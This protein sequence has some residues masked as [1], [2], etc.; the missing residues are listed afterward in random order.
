MATAKKNTQKATEKTARRT[1]RKAIAKVAEG[2]AAAGSGE[3]A[4]GA[5]TAAKRGPGRPPKG[6]ESRTARLSVRLTPAEKSEL[7]GLAE[8]SGE[9]LT[10]FVL[11]AARAR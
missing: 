11:A 3:L 4:P 9:T 1:A 2:Y 10:D 5:K 6:D 7:L 8:G